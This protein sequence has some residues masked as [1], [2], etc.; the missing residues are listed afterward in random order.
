MCKARQ[1]G[2]IWRRYR[3]LG[4]RALSLLHIISFH[5]FVRFW[6]VIDELDLNLDGITPI[7]HVILLD[8]EAIRLN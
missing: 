8:I 3:L 5:Q 7:F 6:H 1:L 4:R 2:E